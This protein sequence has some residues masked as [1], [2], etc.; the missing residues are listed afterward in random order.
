ML[1]WDGQR[2]TTIN[3]TR[4]RRAAH[5]HTPR[6]MRELAQSAPIVEHKSQGTNVRTAVATSAPAATPTEMANATPP[7]QQHAHHELRSRALIIRK[8]KTGKQTTRIP[9]IRTAELRSRPAAAEN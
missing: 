3:N 1:L 6:A 9:I 8:T 2:T 4:L 7:P 5:K